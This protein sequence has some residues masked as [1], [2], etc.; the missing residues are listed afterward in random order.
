MCNRQI[1]L[2]RLYK[3]E[4][5]GAKI[6]LKAEIS[7][8]FDRYIVYLDAPV[9]VRLFLVQGEPDFLFDLHL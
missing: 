8:L 5:R 9:M 7:L 4:Q 6:L 2:Y 1:F 3:T